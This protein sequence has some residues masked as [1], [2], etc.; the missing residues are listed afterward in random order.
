MKGVILA[1]G[2]GT[3]LGRSTSIT[4]KHLLPIWDR[5]MICYP[6]R[7]MIEAGIDE[8]LIVTG[9]RNSGEFMQLL[10][11]G[12]DFGFKN[13]Y[14]AYQRGNCGISDAINYAKQFVNGERFCVML[15]DNILESSIRPCVDAFK[16][17]ASGC[18]FLS[19]E[20]HDPERFGVIE[21][22]NDKPNCVIEKPDNPPSKW[23]AIGV[24]FFDYTVFTRIQNLKVSGRNELEVT[25]LLNSYLQT[26]NASTW[27]IKGFWMDV[28]TVDAIHKAHKIVYDL[29]F[30]PD[31]KQE[32]WTPMDEWA[33][34]K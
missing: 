16:K 1:G 27:P 19:T 6:L 12:H 33:R 32:F 7:T 2:L 24:Y 17:S 4:N 20:V 3:R 23:V 22:N 14:Y 25:G 13:I 21:F 29:W 18:M 10:G 26:N 11:N 31:A 5:P 30:S 15:G 28:G 8:V 34:I 9:G